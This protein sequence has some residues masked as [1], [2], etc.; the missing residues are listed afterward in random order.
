MLMGNKMVVETIK[1]I[2]NNDI[3]TITQ[4]ELA[5]GT[6]LKE[7]PK[8]FK[9]FCDI[10][11]N[12]NCKSIYDH[13]RGLGGIL[14]LEALPFVLVLAN[15]LLVPVESSIQ[16][17]FLKEAEENLEKCHPTEPVGT[18]VTDGKKYLKVTACDG[19]IYLTTIQQAG[20]KAMNITDFLRGFRLEGHWNAFI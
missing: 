1:K 11:W 10:Q 14:I 17:K 9:D 6:D 5:A 13:I 19:Y 12:Q 8:I 4:E 18:I 20:K 16:Q 15:V 7:A 3:Q 2:E